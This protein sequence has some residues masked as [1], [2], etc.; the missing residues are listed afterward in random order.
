M[1]YFIFIS[2]WDQSYFIFL[3][4]FVTFFS[5]SCAASNLSLSPSSLLLQYK[6]L[7]SIIQLYFTFYQRFYEQP[8]KVKDNDDLLKLHLMSSAHFGSKFILF[9][10]ASDRKFFV[11][12]NWK[13]NGSKSS[14]DVII[15]TLKK[16]SLSPNTGILMILHVMIVYS[17][18]CK[19]LSF[20]SIV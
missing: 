6:Q 19:L 8:K 13:M 12:G 16:G 7:N 2:Q 15:D 10:M 20:C 18:L 14:I 11:G 1:N 4:A 5:F 3:S 9:K 17:S